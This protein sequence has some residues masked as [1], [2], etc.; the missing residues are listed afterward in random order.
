MSRSAP[1]RLRF[2]LQSVLERSLAGYLH[3]QGGPTMDFSR[4]VGEPALADPESVCWQ[5]FRNPVSLYVGGVAAVILELAEPRVAAGVWNHTSFRTDPLRRLQR[6]GLAA[7]VT[8]YGARSVAGGMIAG[9]VRAHDAVRGR[10]ADGEAYHANDPELLTWVQATA[11][12]GFL[13]AFAALV[14]PVSA[15]DRDRYYAEGVPAGRLYGVPAPPASEA[16]LRACLAAMQPRLAPSPI[17]HEFLSIMRARPILPLPARPLQPTL[18][19]AAVAILPAWAR[20]RLGLGRAWQ[21]RRAELA[22][23]R[24]AARTAQRLVIETSPAAQACRRLGLPADHLQRRW[25]DR[26]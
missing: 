3:P 5:V 16:A 6:T 8:V 9:I 14:A 13:E 2:G 17:L 18:V 10:T 23:L 4:P 20:D 21:P 7:M 1:L 24:S 12:F 22:L 15:E 11:A 25:A 19:R 26:N